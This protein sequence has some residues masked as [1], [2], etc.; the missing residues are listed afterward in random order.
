MPGAARKHQL[1][2]SL[3]YHIINRGNRRDDVF[4][5][6]EDYEYFIKLLA[7]YCTKFDA[8]IYH[9]VLM[10]NHYHILLEIKNPEHLSRMM[11][12]L[13]R[14]YV[15]YYQRNYN[16]G[17]HI[18]QGRFKSQP[19]EKEP[20]LLACGRYIERNPLEAKMVN[21]AEEYE[22]S[23]AKFYVNGAPD[24][25]TKEDPYFESFGQDVSQR[26]K[27]YAEFLKEFNEE[28]KVLFENELPLGNGQFKAKLFYAE[29]RYMPRRKGKASRVVLS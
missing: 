20:Y 9:W 26:R 24:H 21:S 1:Q 19:I 7:D 10:P 27:N 16:L 18:W 12:G 17:G 28:E 14:A 3:I 13:G 29:G 25:L 5:Y 6:P 15:Y 22:Y 11:A 23:S 4:H 8:L 2:S